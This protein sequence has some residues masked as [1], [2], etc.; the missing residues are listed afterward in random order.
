[1]KR[2]SH[3]AG[4]VEDDQALSWDAAVADIASATGDDES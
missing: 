4:R 2:L 3:T 1:M